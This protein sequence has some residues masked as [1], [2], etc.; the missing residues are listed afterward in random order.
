MID[1]SVK[2]GKTA[3]TLIK[4]EKR[5]LPSPNT[6]YD[7]W[8]KDMQVSFEAESH[9]VSRIDVGS[10][11]KELRTRQGLSQ[12]DLARQIGVTASTISQVEGNLI[13][14]SLPA[15]LKLAEVLSVEVG[16]LFQ[17][18]GRIHRKIHFTAVDALDIRSPDFPRALVTGKRL[19]PLNVDADAEPYL[20]DI[21]PGLTLQFHFFV[22]TGQEFGYL[23][24]G[25]L[26]LTVN[27]TEHTL[28]PG[29]L[30]YLTSETPG[31]WVNSGPD[32]ARLLWVTIK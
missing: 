1:L 4:A 22:H 19:L 15:L 12:S 28:K 29:E 2:R 16:R 5:H 26:H 6:P 7:Y 30:V 18:S 8:A 3:L 20:V 11:L 21:P 17:E 32:T 13:Y 25:E 14:P 23:L 27:S 24:S 10:R 31:Q 9:P